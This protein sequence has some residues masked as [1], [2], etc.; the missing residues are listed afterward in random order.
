MHALA[1]PVRHGASRPTKPFFHFP[2]SFLIENGYHAL[3][4]VALPPLCVLSILTFCLSS[5][6]ASAREQISLD[7][8]WLFHLHEIDTG[9]NDATAPVFDD[10]Q[11]QHVDVPH[12]Y[13][14]D[15]TYNKTNEEKHGYLPLDIG[16]YRKHFTIPASAGGKIL[17][18][19][20][21]GI[22]RDSKVWV[23]GHYLGEHQSGYTS[24]SYDI[25]PFAKIGDGAD[26]DNVISVRVDPRQFEGHW[27]EGGGIY[28]H[29]R[30]T[31]LNPLHVAQYGTYVIS[32]VGQTSQSAS[33]NFA[34]SSASLTIQTTVQN[35][36]PVQTDCQIISEII[37]PDGK[38]IA[39]AK[40]NAIVPANGQ[41]QTDQKIT[42]ANPQLW[43]LESPNLY[44]LRTTILDT[45]SRSS[46]H[47][48]ALTLSR[49]DPSIPLAIQSDQP[50]DGDSLTTVSVSDLTTTSFGIR[51]L[52]YDPDHGF[53]LNG[54]H[55]EIQGTAN[56]QDFP[57]VG[58]AMPDCLQSW[59]V[60]KLKA[61]GCNA[62]RT[63]HNPPSDAL[64]DACD[65]LG[66]MVMDENR[67]LGDSY[68]GHSPHGTTATNLSDLATMIR[69]DRNH[70][71]IIMWSLCN[72]E[73]LRQRPEGKRLFA[74]MKRVVHLYDDTRPITCA[75]N[76]DALTNALTDE[77]LIG[78]NYRYRDYNG[79]HAADPHIPMFASEANN[80]KTTRGE[81]AIEDDRAA[82]MCSSY[83]LSDKTWLEQAPRRY[84]CG[85]FTWT[86]FDYKG[87]PNPYG[88]PDVSN[89][90][91]L[92][93]CCGFP[94]EKYYYFES[95]WSAKPMVHIMPANW[96]WHGKEGQ[97]IHVLVCSNAKRVE[98]SLNG[99][100]LGIKDVPYD[101]YA[102]W[103]VPY[104]PGRL[105][106]KAFNSPQSDEDVAATDVV[107]TTGAPASIQLSPDR[108]TLQASADAEDAVVV[109]V[110]I[111]DAQGRV[112][113]DAANRVTFDVTA[114]PVDGGA[115]N[116]V[117]RSHVLMLSQSCI[118]GVSNGNPADHDADRSNQRNAFHGHCMVLVGLK[119]S[120]SLARRS[121]ASRDEDGSSTP[122]TIHLTA[123]SPG[124]D[125][126]SVDFE[127]R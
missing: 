118:L 45:G 48:S 70:P 33:D 59:R 27:Y 71:S 67:H 9:G 21:D 14:L 39:S 13:V 58:I 105:E 127:V 81:Y 35:E 16:W 46:G 122:E 76:S 106:A 31:I 18:L 12:D 74:A 17:R 4:Q 75:I 93:D 52:R 2:F 40:S 85:A 32:T 103:E 80:Q 29:V 5:L 53:F 117:S 3:W 97:N 43:S 125:S 36:S 65:R 41:T 26:N 94:K 47:K 77:D 82:G 100:S 83:N 99:K 107:E 34:N 123:T 51:T 7:A 54:K 49:N 96:N 68:L 101:D 37:S 109:P 23:N 120:S 78:V 42:I 90:T 73:G 84:I 56:H 113:P 102:G 104:Q 10:A 86:G 38:L 108:T 60:E 64:L 111:V 87:E 55:V 116:R 44:Q 1:C 15:G 95:C 25:T 124:L 114:G 61:M 110:S 63:A 89:N 79:I 72:E 11:W 112:V 6:Q 28:R 98:L 91:G 57:G 115:A 24:F 8:N 19:E 66:M 50:S 62:W 30:L 22:F 88:W 20:F 69:R 119:G 126:A 121:P 92:M